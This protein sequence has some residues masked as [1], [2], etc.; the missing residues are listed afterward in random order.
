V[1]ELGDWA[2]VEPGE[3][4]AAGALT[5]GPVLVLLA[6]LAVAMAGMMAG[7]AGPELRHERVLAAGGW[8]VPV[9]MLV[10]AAAGV[11]SVRR[12]GLRGLP[13]LWRGAT[14]VAV[15]LALLGGAMGLSTLLP[16]SELPLE[17]VVEASFCL[18]PAAGRPIC[19][20]EL[21]TP[22]ELAAL[23][24]VRIGGPPLALGTVL[25]LVLVRPVAGP[26]RVRSTAADVLDWHPEGAL[27]ELFIDKRTR[28]PELLRAGQVTAQGEFAPGSAALAE[29][30]R[31]GIP[32]TGGS[33]P[34]PGGVR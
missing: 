14:F 32:R 33:P 21:R 4:V 10:A 28:M 9:S 15:P 30:D 26:A 29:L 27:D 5:L 25:P 1:L 18:H 2:L 31:L 22:P 19:L 34:A 23:R 12:A 11:W 3:P 17:V 16:A 13:A 6:L 20:L 7:F 24:R 8:V